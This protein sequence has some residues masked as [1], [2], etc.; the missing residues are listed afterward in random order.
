MPAVSLVFPPP[1]VDA[2]YARTK[3]T[4]SREGLRRVNLL[5]IVTRSQRGRGIE[6]GGAMMKLEG[7]FSDGS[8]KVILMPE[9][10]REML[11]NTCAGA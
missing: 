3:T 4:I 5:K 6:S 1:V 2:V 8:R 11:R 7:T 9:D 10:G